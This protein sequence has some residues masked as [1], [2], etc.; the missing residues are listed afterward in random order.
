VVAHGAIRGVEDCTCSHKQLQTLVW[1]PCQWQ[2][3][4]ILEASQETSSSGVV[5]SVRSCINT[6]QWHRTSLVMQGKSPG[7]HF[8]LTSR[9][10]RQD[11]NSSPSIAG[12]AACTISYI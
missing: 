2:N 6:P 7:S 4:L 9:Q 12:T 3:R 8:A 11:C 10:Q 1:Q 5:E